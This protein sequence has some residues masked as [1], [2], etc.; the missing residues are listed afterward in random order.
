M[1]FQSV[2]SWSMLVAGIL[3]LIGIIIK[4]EVT[5]SYFELG[6]VLG[7]GFGNAVYGCAV[8]MAADSLGG[9]YAGPVTIGITLA[10]FVRAWRLARCL[11]HEFNQPDTERLVNEVKTQLTEAVEQEARQ[12]VE[13]R[14]KGGD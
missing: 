7:L 13:N 4:D 12:I 8:L 6:G 3:A 11:W 1:E 5:G 14:D 10:C 9:T 2:W